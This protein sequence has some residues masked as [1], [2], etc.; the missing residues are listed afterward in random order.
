MN[1]TPK[2]KIPHVQNSSTI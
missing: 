1:E 2:N